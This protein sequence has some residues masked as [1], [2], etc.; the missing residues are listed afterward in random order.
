MNNF[1]STQTQP[2]NVLFLIDELNDWN[3][4]ETHL[5]KLLT[6]LDSRKIKPTV[7]IIGKNRLA[8]DFRQ[9]GIPVINLHCAKIFSFNG[10]KTL[11]KLRKHT[12][13]LDAS[14]IVSYHTAADIL[15]PLLSLLSKAICISSRRDEGFT[16]KKIHTTLQRYLNHFVIQMISVSHAVVRSVEKS[17]HYP[18]AKNTVIW[19][20]EDLAKFSPSGKNIRAELGI[21]QK[22]IVFICVASLSKVKDHYSLLTAYKNLLKTH[23]N[24]CL[25]LVGEGSERKHLMNQFSELGN[26]VHF[27]GHRVDI[28][29]LL[30]SSDIYLQTSITEG[31]SNAIIQAMAC[32][33]PIITT[34]V[35]GNTELVAKECGYL[36]PPK[37]PNAILEAATKLVASEEQ[38]TQFGIAARKRAE[39]YCSLSAMTE[40][41][42]RTIVTAV[43]KPFLRVVNK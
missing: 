21:S 31:F 5:L 3:G 35:G 23:H 38:R 28:P 26:A 8:N 36:V 42:T 20:G 15:A 22:T 41:Y 34:A 27:M 19:N 14:L 18:S 2:I 12:A 6:N 43:Q 24:L 37:N 30:R 11:L 1:N 39:Q 29:E 7:A 4:T 32:G 13:R 17:E 16:K 33:L 9:M 40:A 25:L 10:L